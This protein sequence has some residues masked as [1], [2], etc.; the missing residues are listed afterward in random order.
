MPVYCPIREARIP[1]TQIVVKVA[2][3]GERKDSPGGEATR[4]AGSRR[5]DPQTRVRMIFA[6]R[7]DVGSGQRTYSVVTPSG[8]MTFS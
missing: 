6:T 5:R 7:F 2:L 3:A 4:T 8:S 1:G